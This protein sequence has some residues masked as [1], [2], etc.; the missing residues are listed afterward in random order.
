VAS[1]LFVRYTGVGFF[2]ALKLWSFGDI[3]RCMESYTGETA[4]LATGLF[5]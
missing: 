2:S 5:V 4:G 1:A 3:G